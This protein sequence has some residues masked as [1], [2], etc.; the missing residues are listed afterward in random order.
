MIAIP[1]QSP[2]Y[3]EKF[4]FIDGE[5][6]EK[7]KTHIWCVSYDPTIKN[8]YVTCTDRTGEKQTSIRLHRFILDAPN[9]MHVDHIDGN[10]LN[11]QKENLRLCTHQQNSYNRKKRVCTNKTKYKGVTK[12]KY[13]FE[14]SIGYNGKRIYLGLFSTQEEAAAKYN[15][16]ALKYFGEFARLNIIEEYKC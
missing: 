11:N 5:D 13:K 14:A 4:F 7:V 2:K 6:L 3:G 8:F 1:V 10:P 15:E 12:N 16:A 9:N